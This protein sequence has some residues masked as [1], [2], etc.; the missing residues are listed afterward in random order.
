MLNVDNICDFKNETSS[1][2]ILYIY[3][4]EDT[5]IR[6]FLRQRK[7]QA[8]SFFESC[9]IVVDFGKVED[10]NT[11][12][13]LNIFS[14]LKEEG[15]LPVGVKNIKNKLK[16][17]LF[18]HKIPTYTTYSSNEE[19]SAKQE[20]KNNHEM[21]EATEE[22]KE[23]VK[24]ECKRD[25][26]PLTKNHFEPLRSGQKLSAK[27]MNLT[28]FGSVQSSAEVVSSGSIVICGGLYGRAAAG[29][30]GDESATIL[31]MKFD[32]V[33]VSIGGH[34]ILFEDGVPDEYKEKP[35]LV[36]VENGKIR[37]RKL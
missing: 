27:D 34:Y 36:Y 19:T 32:P 35:A 18:E 29:I 1:I 28:V 12:F 16:S 14:I 9:P 3:G 24:V 22:V 21:V 11:T 2:T 13:V 10:Y 20:S 30:D 7:K 6:K 26:L 23:E 25:S 33:L 31:T 4:I 17:E 5:E 15:F 8:K 37:I